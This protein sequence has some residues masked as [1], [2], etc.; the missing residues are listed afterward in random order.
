MRILQGFL[1]NYYGKSTSQ[2]VF[3]L[4]CYWLSL[5]VLKSA[6]PLFASAFSGLLLCENIFKIPYLVALLLVVCAIALA[7][8][9]I[10]KKR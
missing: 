10:S 8:A 3:D 5:A 2:N 1:A 6:D 7:N 9:K 4:G